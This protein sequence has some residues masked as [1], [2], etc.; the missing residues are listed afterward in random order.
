MLAPAIAA[1]ANRF[2]KNKKPASQIQRSSVGTQDP[3][4]R[5]QK[6][7][8]LVR[9]AADQFA[10][11]ALEKSR[12]HQTPSPTLYSGPTARKNAEEDERSRGVRVLAGL[13]RGTD[14]P[15]EQLLAEQAGNAQ[16]LGGGRRASTL[17][18]RVRARP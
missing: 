15:M 8:K 5:R 4:K 7:V 17:R 11:A 6:K 14:T 10:L 1:A 18:D 16:V 2:D 9:T 13:V 3:T 12:R